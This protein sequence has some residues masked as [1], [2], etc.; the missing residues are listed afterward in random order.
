MMKFLFIALLVII[1]GYVISKRN[2]FNRLRRAVQQQ[3][4]DIGIQISKRTA[5]LNDALTIAKVSYEKE[6]AGIEQLSPNDKMEKLRYLG[7]LYPELMSTQGYQ[8]ALMQS[9]E[10]NKDISAT[11]EL[12]NGNIRVY[13]DAISDFPGLIVAKLFGYEPEKFIDEENIEENKKIDK[14]DVDFSKF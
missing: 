8:T 9:F 6:L 14:T 13:N 4:S 2:T 7:E 11:R 3:G 5:C 1:V 10:L 12:L